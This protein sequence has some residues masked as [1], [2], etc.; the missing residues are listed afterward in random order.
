MAAMTAAFSMLNDRLAAGFSTIFGPLYSPGYL[1]RFARTDNGKGGVATSCVAEFPVRVQIDRS[2]K[3]QQAQGYAE[4]DATF[5]IL[6][7]GVP[8]LRDDDEV[9]VDDRIWRI[10]GPETDPL[11]SHWV[12]RARRKP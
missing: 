2:G 11:K 1:R 7:H 8:E 6:A 10:A 9:T 5:I 4:G 12:A 3:R